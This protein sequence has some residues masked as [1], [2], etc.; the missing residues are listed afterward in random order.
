MS[1]ARCRAPSRVRQAPRSRP[2]LGENELTRRVRRR[3]SFKSGV[4]ALQ[5]GIPCSATAESAALRREGVLLSASA[6]YLQSKRARGR[7]RGRTGVAF[8]PNPSWSADPSQSN[9]IEKRNRAS[10]RPGTRL[11][12]VPD[13]RT[14]PQTAG[15]TPVTFNTTRDA[16]RPGLWRPAPGRG[17]MEPT[18]APTFRDE[19][20]AGKLSTPPTELLTRDRPLNAKNRTSWCPDRPTGAAPFPSFRRG[21]AG[22]P[23]VGVT[24]KPYI[25]AD[26]RS[27]SKYKGNLYLSYTFETT[28]R[29]SWRGS[30]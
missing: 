9:S 22:A 14:T 13:S 17:R 26:A 16:A 8:G 19:R 11:N 1:I 5:G 30:G 20:L 21:R 7:R 23:G 2:L 27:G 28:Y 18:S 24:D 12:V 4:H 6:F 10:P 15:G 29:R 25:A 3:T